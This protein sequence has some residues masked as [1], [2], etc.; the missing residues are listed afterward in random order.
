MYIILAED[1]KH[2]YLKFSVDNNK[3]AF[4]QTFEMEE[5][6]STVEKWS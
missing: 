5:T 4:V 3:A 2:A 6:V 1:A